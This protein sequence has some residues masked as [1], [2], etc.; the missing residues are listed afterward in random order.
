[1]KIYFI[2]NTH[3]ENRNYRGDAYFG[4]I[5][6]MTFHN[7]K[8]MPPQEEWDKANDFNRW[9]DEQQLPFG[10]HVWYGS[11]EKYKLT[12]DEIYKR[13]IEGYEGGAHDGRSMKMPNDEKHTVGAF[14]KALAFMVE[15]K[16]VTVQIVD[17]GVDSPKFVV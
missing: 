4:K 6:M 15:K 2:R 8:P 7:T 3:D 9:F 13:I 14:L 12:F 5:D 1:M 11:G 17:D 10:V 16:L